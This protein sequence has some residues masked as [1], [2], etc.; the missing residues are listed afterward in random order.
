MQVIGFIDTFLNNYGS[1][2]YGGK[3]AENG[4][5]SVR[6]HAH[7]PIFE[8]LPVNYGIPTIILY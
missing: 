3:N 4:G 5:V 1:V 6:T 8:P 7:T 2:A